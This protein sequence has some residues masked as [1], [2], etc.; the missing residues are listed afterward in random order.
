MKVKPSEGS[1]HVILKSD[2][3]E[4]QRLQQRIARQLSKTSFDQR[5]IFGISLALEEALVNAIKH[6]NRLDPKKKVQ[7]RFQ[8]TP[9]RFEIHIADEGPGFDPCDVRDPLADENLTRPGGRGLLLMRHYMTEV[10][11]H[12]PGNQLSMMKVHRNGHAVPAAVR[13]V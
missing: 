1:V 2:L 11:V 10:V 8:V 12:P 9:D 7:V 3:K 13:E 4:A 6:G 5:E